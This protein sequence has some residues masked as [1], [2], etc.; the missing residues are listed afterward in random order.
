ME[1]T[2]NTII[3]SAKE[4]MINNMN[5][6]NSSI[7]VDNTG[8]KP[9]DQ[10]PLYTIRSYVDMQLKTNRNFLRWIFNDYDHISDFGKGMSEEQKKAFKEWYMTLEN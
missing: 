9:T 8:K 4:L 7:E 5:W 6:M 2:K 3:K 1:T 10:T